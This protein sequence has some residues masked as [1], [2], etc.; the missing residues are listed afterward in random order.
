MNKSAE[1][2]IGLRDRMIKERANLSPRLVQI[3]DYAIENP[4]DMALATV[5]TIANNAQVQPSALIRFANHF[6]FSGFSQM[7]K[8]Y[9]ERLL[10]VGLNYN[11]RINLLSADADDKGDFALMSDFVQG[12]VTALHSLTSELNLAAFE[13]AIEILAQA[14]TIWIAGVRRSYP[15]A[16]YF[17]YALSQLGKS[18]IILD[19]TGF[20]TNVHSR[21]MHSG[22]VILAISF[23][24]YAKEVQEIMDKGREKGAK[25]VSITDSVFSP[26]V[27]KSDVSLEIH[28]V[29]VHAFRSLSTSMCLA[30]SMV[31]ALG[32]HMRTQQ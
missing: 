13:K 31:V 6:G 26:L 8:V 32:N 3:A 14:E 30:L 24:D 28:E 1:S 2:F 9:K 18:N 11:E 21:N 5:A 22:D 29:E 19:G 25:I 23:K 16:A 27:T 12:S 4:D 10:R 20:M 17:N 7:Q 15:I